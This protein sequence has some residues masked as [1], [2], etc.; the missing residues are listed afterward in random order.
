M[1]LWLWWRGAMNNHWTREEIAL[2]RRA[3]AIRDAMD[4]RK[5]TRIDWLV[6]LVSLSLFFLVFLSYGG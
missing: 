5:F 4:E 3:W 1:G 2:T 6:S